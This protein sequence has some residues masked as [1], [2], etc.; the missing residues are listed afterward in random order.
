MEDLMH[1]MR[2]EPAR[3]LA[4]PILCRQIRDTVAELLPNWKGDD[5]SPE[6]LMPDGS[7]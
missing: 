3:N 1:E 4:V 7:M 6:Q 5:R 2:G